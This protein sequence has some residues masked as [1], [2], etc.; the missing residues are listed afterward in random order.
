MVKWGFKFQ[1][2]EYEFFENVNCCVI[3]LKSFG[4]I[5]GSMCLDLFTKMSSFWYIYS[6]GLWKHLDIFEIWNYFATIFAL[7]TTHINLYVGMIIQM[8]LST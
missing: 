8:M 1:P 6:F 5:E 2:H 4:T 7:N 3:F